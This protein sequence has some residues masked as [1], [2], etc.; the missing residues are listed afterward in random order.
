MNLRSRCAMTSR[1]VAPTAS[2]GALRDAGLV[3]QRHTV[4]T[5]D[6]RRSRPRS[7]SVT[8]R[9]H[10]WQGR[11]CRPHRRFRNCCSATRKAQVGAVHAAGEDGCGVIENG[12]RARRAPVLRSGSDRP[13]GR[14]FESAQAPGVRAASRR[15]APSTARVRAPISTAF[16]QR[17]A[18]RRDAR[19]AAD[20][21][22]T[23]TERF[24]S[25]RREKESGRM[26]FHLDR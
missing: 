26:G 9:R 4:D 16:R 20:T 13:S 17:L 5:F 25:Y 11:I 6:G 14:H 3:D 7:D 10:A 1:N 21:A 18:R 8:A 22:P 15:P 2:S 12:V 19:M 24:F 23:E